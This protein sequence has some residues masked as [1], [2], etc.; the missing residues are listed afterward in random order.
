MRTIEWN[1]LD[2]RHPIAKRQNSSYF[3]DCNE[4]DLWVDVEDLFDSTDEN[5]KDGSHLKYIVNKKC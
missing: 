3:M 4:P 2:V 5:V 1:E